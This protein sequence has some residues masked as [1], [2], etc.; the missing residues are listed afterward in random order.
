MDGRRWKV[1]V[2]EMSRVLS[3]GD[4]SAADDRS[5]MQ[6]KPPGR[7]GRRPRRNIRST[8][9]RFTLRTLFVSTLT[10]TLTACMVGPDYE[11]PDTVIPDQWPMEDKQSAERA[12]S[13]W[14]SLFNDPVLDELIL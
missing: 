3:V 1:R 14:C 6:T 5:Y 4:M 12:N 7:S 8:L 10:L 9:H 2:V 11:K 13:G